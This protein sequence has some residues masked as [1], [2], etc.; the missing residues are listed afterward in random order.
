MT[1]A[2]ASAAAPGAAAAVPAAEELIGAPKFS[3]AAG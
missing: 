2:G 3:S 1:S